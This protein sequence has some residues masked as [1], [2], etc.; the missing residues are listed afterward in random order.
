[1]GK[2]TTLFGGRVTLSARAIAIGIDNDIKVFDTAEFSKYPKE[3]SKEIEKD[4]DVR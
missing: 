3:K 4:Q 2:T 1:M